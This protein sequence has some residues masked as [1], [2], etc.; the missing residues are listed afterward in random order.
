[1]AFFLPKLVVVGMHALPLIRCSFAYFSENSCQ[2]VRF[3]K[4]DFYTELDIVKSH[5]HFIGNHQGCRFMAGFKGG[6]LLG[7]FVLVSNTLIQLLG[8][9][10]CLFLN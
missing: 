6:I 5:K 4:S 9:G 2:S 10:F 3:I 7:L 8:I 1:M